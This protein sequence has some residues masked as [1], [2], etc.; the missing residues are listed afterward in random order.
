M[1]TA[2]EFYKTWLSKDT[3]IVFEDDFFTKVFTI[4]FETLRAHL[5]MCGALKH[6]MQ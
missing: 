5:H 3:V 2:N 4:Q 1:T 6:T